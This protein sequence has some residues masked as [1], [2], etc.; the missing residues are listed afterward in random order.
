MSIKYS[1]TPLIS[2]SNPSAPPRYYAR[3]QARE[4]VSE[5][6]ICRRIAYATSLTEGDVRNVIRSLG[7]EIKSRLM[8]GDLVQLGSFGS[9]QFQVQSE[10]TT[11]REDFNCY[12]IKGAKL[13]FRPGSIFTAGLADLEFEE[14][15]PV[16][17]KKQVKKDLKNPDS[18]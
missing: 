15:I 16:K 3:C 10:G 12:K 13:Q 11:L 5:D 14:V 17:I 7:W 18:I 4:T 6:F 2:P 9:F 8:E 1:I